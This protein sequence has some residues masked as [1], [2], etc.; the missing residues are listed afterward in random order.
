VKKV[1]DFF[2]SSK[3][4][5]ILFLVLAGVSILGTI[6]PQ[7]MPPQ[8]YFH[9]YGDLG[10]LI[11]KFRIDD[12]YHSSWYLFLLGVFLLNLILC[13]VKHFPITLK[14]YKKKPVL[15]K[16]RFPARIE[17]V[18]NLDVKKTKNFLLKEGFKVV[19]ENKRRI[20]FIKRKNQLSWFAVY[21]VHFAV[22]LVILGG[23]LGNILGFRGSMVLFPGVPT[24]LVTCFRSNKPVFLPF[25]IKLKK[26]EIKFYPDG[27]PKAYI[28]YVE[29]LDNGKTFSKTIRVNHPLRYKGVSFYQANFKVIPEFQIEVVQGDRVGFF[30]L[31]SLTPLNVWNKYSIKL[32]KAGRRRGLIYGEIEFIDTLNRKEYKGFI[33]EGFPHFVVPTKEG[34]LKIIL[35]G[36]KDVKYISILEVTKDPGVFLVYL[37]F[38]IIILGIGW[39]FFLPPKTYYAYLKEENSKVKVIVGAY[40]KR[41][42]DEVKKELEK[43]LAKMEGACK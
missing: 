29:V 8:Y 4:G 25:F 42:R 2:S 34:K 37:G 31:N 19:K 13:S 39:I 22:L 1:L 26:F 21:V 9:K 41:G 28:S 16:S 5:L 40:V 3:L 35:L 23:I 18:I 33:I 24:N 14:L 17:K 30:V 12:M 15:E 11:V 36:L 6:I 27:T 20:Y 7:G 32:L 38:V 10:N 43:L